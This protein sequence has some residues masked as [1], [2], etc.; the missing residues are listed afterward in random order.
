MGQGVLV[1]VVLLILLRSHLLTWLAVLLLPGLC[2]FLLGV[3]EQFVSGDE[4]A[5]S[6]EHRFSE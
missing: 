6:P 4:T 2:I 3:A 5:Y 1:F